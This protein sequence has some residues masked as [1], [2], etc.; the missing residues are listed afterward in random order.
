MR[1][2]DNWVLLCKNSKVEVEI[3]SLCYRSLQAPGLPNRIHLV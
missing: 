3:E 2:N 1:L